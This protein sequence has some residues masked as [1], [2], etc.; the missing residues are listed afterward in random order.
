MRLG[1]DKTQALL[2]YAP[3][4]HLT[5]CIHYSVLESQLPYKTVYSTF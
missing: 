2:E 1:P 5:A 3:N 4:S